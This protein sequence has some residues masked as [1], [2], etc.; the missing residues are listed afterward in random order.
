MFDKVQKYD[1]L[2]LFII[3]DMLDKY[4]I[5]ENY[6]VESNF[7]IHTYYEVYRLRKK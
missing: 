3:A 4:P 7:A 5:P 6:E 2:Y 1:S